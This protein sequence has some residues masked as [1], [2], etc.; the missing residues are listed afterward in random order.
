MTNPFVRRHYILSC[1]FPWVG[2]LTGSQRNLEGC[3]ASSTNPAFLQGFAAASRHKATSKLLSKGNR[4]GR[5]L[6][7]CYPGR[8]ASQCGQTAHME[9]GLYLIWTADTSADRRQSCSVTDFTGERV[10]QSLPG[11]LCD[12]N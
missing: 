3:W 11:D 2:Q 9:K 5:R 4:V 12:L 7:Q 10:A 8:Q 6:G 1:G